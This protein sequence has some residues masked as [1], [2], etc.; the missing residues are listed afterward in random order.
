M[1]ESCGSRNRAH[2]KNENHRSGVVLVDLSQMAV[3]SVAKTKKNVTI[4]RVWFDMEVHMSILKQ[5]RGENFSVY[6]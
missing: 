3:K 6:V 5:C 4:L 1:A 2:D